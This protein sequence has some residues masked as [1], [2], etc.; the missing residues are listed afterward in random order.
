MP[1]W[2]PSAIVTSSSSSPESGH[3]TQTYLRLSRMGS[4]DT[5]SATA[6]EMGVNWMRLFPKLPSLPAALV[7][8]LDVERCMAGVAQLK[9]DPLLLLPGCFEAVAWP[10]IQLWL[11]I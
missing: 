8:A 4:C 3:L 9:L 1:F 10:W 2:R 6:L 7:L 5:N 11:C